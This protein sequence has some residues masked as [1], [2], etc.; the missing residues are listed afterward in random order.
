M[1]SARWTIAPLDVQ[2]FLDQKACG[3][4]EP[5]TPAISFRTG[6]ASG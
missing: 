5:G 1:R 4:V 3:R 6:N 2:P